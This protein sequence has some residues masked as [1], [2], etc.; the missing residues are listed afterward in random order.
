MEGVEVIHV[1]LISD[2]MKTRGWLHAWPL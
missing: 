2:Q 1:F